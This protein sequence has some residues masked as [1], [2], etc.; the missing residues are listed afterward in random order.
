MLTITDFT[1]V[2][3][4]VYGNPRYYVPVYRLPK[5][6]DKKRLNV[7]LEKYRGKKFGPG[8][9]VQSYNL[10]ATCNFINTTLVL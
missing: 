8:Y 2:D 4:D 3:N 6:A 10:Q 9:V 7:G 5:L 1:R